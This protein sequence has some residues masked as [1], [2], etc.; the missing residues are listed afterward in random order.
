MTNIKCSFCKN[1]LRTDLVNFKKIPIAN[2]YKKIINPTFTKYN[3][4]IKVCK[5]CLLV[6]STNKIHPKKIYKNYFFN[7]N[8]SKTWKKH[9]KKLVEEISSNNKNKC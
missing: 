3:L 8:S 2:Y 5:K 1:P 9:C 6:Q 4:Q 7:S